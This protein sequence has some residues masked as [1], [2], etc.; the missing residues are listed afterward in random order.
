MAD[1]QTAIAKKFEEEFNKLGVPQSPESLTKF[2]QAMAECFAKYWQSELT[3]I[4]GASY[5]DIVHPLGYTPMVTLFTNGTLCTLLDAN[6]S[7]IRV[8]NPGATEGS[9][10]VRCT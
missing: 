2:C 8:W 1:R 6:N 4:K 7:Y 3:I 10:W 9:C 5:V